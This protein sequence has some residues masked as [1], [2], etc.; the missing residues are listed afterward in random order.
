MKTEIIFLTGKSPSAVIQI[1]IGRIIVF[2]DF[3][4]EIPSKEHLN[5]LLEKYKKIYEEYLK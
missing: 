3:Y 2:A 5:G 4:K 1:K